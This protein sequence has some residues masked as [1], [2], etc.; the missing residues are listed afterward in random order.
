MN[1]VSH[2]NSHPSPKRTRELV[3]RL[4]R[5]YKLPTVL[6]I[7]AQ[8]G[9]TTSLAS[10][11]AAHPNVVSPRSKEVHFFDLDYEK[12]AEWY[13]SQ[14]PV[15]ARRRLG[16]QWHHG[17]LLAFDAT[18][19]YILHP[20]AAVRASRLIPNARIIILLRD[21]VHR[22]YSHY[23]HEVR[24]GNECLSFENAIAAEPSRIAG[25]AERLR[26][27]PF[28]QSFG[29]Q[30]FSYLERGNYSDQIRQWL[31]HFRP[32]QFLV[33]SSEQFFENPANEYRRV[34]RFLGLPAWEL[35]SYPAEHVGR[36]PPMP[37]H[38]RDRL[39]EYYAGYNRTLRSYLNSHWPDIGDAVVDRFVA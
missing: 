12:G 39:V 30:H 32:D 11:L 20:Q 22:A 9:G 23:Y 5:T 31:N 34:L 24:L 15:G 13:R 37:A 29:Y 28:Y 18:P 16:S 14:F 2:L 35:P 7:G 27:E 21:P 8:K 4:L 33:L 17:R 19:Y 38:I 1:P 26:S 36:Y 6:I 10:Y 3:A 25:E